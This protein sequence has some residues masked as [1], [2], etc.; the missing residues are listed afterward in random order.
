MVPIQP[1]ADLG[2]GLAA[3]SSSTSVFIEDLHKPWKIMDPDRHPESTM[4]DMLQGNEGKYTF[5]KF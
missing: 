2:V 3:G 4:S 5:H 1:Q